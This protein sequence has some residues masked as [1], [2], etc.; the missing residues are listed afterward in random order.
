MQFSRRR[1][2]AAPAV[3]LGDAGPFGDRSAATFGP[4]LYPPCPNPCQTTLLADLVCDVRTAVDTSLSNLFCCVLGMGQQLACGCVNAC[5]CGVPDYGCGAAGIGAGCGAAAYGGGCDCA[6][7][8]GGGAAMSQPTPAYPSPATQPPT[9]AP[10]QPNPFSDDAP[11]IQPIPGGSTS[12]NELPATRQ[13]SVAQQPRATSRV[14][15]VTHQQ[16]TRPTPQAAPAR[17]K[18]RVVEA[19][20]IPAQA[21]SHYTPRRSAAIRTSNGRQLRKTP[22]RTTSPKSS[23]R[24]R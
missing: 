12:R 23:L 22:V 24:F 7:C 5:S 19:R 2:I 4:G 16:V 10:T 13:R 6:E 9:V 20:P 17:I 8:V 3:A 21:Q 18:P 15:R 1:A 14:K 11:A